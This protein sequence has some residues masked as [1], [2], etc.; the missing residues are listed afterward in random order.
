M[1]IFLDEERRSMSTSSQQREGI[2]G[3]ERGMESFE[4]KQK[5]WTGTDG[6]LS[7]S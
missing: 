7:Y 2:Q 4:E 1:E 6:P 5:Y 3:S